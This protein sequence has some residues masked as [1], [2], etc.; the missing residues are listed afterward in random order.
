LILLEFTKG[1]DRSGG[2]LYINPE[3]VIKVEVNPKGN[4]SGSMI[5]LDDGHLAQ[6]AENIQDVILDLQEIEIDEE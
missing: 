4:A 3:K 5:F 2:K 6:V 1:F